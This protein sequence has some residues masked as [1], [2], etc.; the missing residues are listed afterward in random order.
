MEGNDMNTPTV[1]YGYWIEEGPLVDSR[2]DFRGRG[3]GDGDCL[4][5]SV[6]VMALRSIQIEHEANR[7]S[8]DS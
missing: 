3:D 7:D 8:W 4:D 1:A 6:T 2:R 5:R